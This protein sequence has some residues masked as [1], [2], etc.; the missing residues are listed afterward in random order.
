ME[1]FLLKKVL[2]CIVMLQLEYNENIFLFMVIVICYIEKQDI[3]YSWK[4]DY[5]DWSVLFVDNRICFLNFFLG[6][7]IF[8]VW[9]LFI[10]NGW[11]FV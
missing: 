6:E 9:V 2:N 10:D 8:F 7:Y 3:V 4:F 11:L 5:M 1:N